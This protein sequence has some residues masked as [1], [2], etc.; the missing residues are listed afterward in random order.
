MMLSD[1]VEVL[2]QGTV[3]DEARP[4]LHANHMPR[5][6]MRRSGWTTPKAC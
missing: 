3:G 5:A 2:L 4:L 6:V 1:H